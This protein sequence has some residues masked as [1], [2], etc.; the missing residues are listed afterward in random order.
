MPGGSSAEIYL[1]GA[2]SD[3]ILAL[4]GQLYT[5]H[6]LSRVDAHTLR[7]P[8]GGLTYL[9]LPP[10]H[11]DSL[12]SLLTLDLPEGIRKGEQF[13]VVVRQLTSVRYGEV[14]EA[15]DGESV[16]AGRMARAAADFTYRRTAGMFALDIPVGTK[17]TLLAPEER[18][19][20]I[21]RWIGTSVA[22]DSRWYLVF[23][24]YLEQLAGRVDAMGGDSG[25]V[26][27]SPTGAWH[28]RH[29]HHHD[30]ESLR[31]TRGKIAG[32]VHDHFGD[33]A[34]FLL[35]T[36]EGETRH[37]DSREH[38]MSELVTG[39]WRDRLL[40]EGEAERH[41]PRAVIALIIRDR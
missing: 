19:L 18:Y 6:R 38:R 11:A 20:S 5:T 15:R 1:P 25:A 23:Q 29:H 41:E 13:R 9:P 8:A 21:M 40:V 31:H 32:I 2:S 36:P 4:A 27:P 26:L 22:P 33:F 16:V 24:R 39:A 12:T 7:C 14:I 28:H 30:G 10:G 3:A 34:G 17:A 35:E 37:F